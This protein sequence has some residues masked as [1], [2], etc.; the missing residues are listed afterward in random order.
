VKRPCDLISL[1]GR[2]LESSGR[3]T[4]P[5]I[6]IPRR[7]LTH[8]LDAF[9]DYVHP[10]LPVMDL[11]ALCGVCSVEVMIDRYGL[12]LSFAVLATSVAHADDSHI[13]ALGHSSPRRA[14]NHYANQAKVEFGRFPLSALN[15]NIPGTNL[16]GV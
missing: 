4:K 8:L 13:T 6:K 2:C 11:E 5:S 7:I 16:D 3:D 15:A 9:V 14:S 12:F 1:P 10:Q